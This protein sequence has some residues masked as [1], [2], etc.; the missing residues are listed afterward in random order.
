MQQKKKTS[1]LIPNR[2]LTNYELEDY[3]NRLNIPHFRGV[4]MRD[5]LP[6]RVREFETGIVN[7]DSSSGPG[8]HWVCY[9]KTGELV[10]YF[11]G[12]GNLR[13]PAELVAYLGQTSVI[14]YNYERRQS[15]D[16]VICG[17]LC[18]RFLTK[19]ENV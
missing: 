16:S 6:A 9:R 19:K 7:L 1:I 18:L 15:Y 10:S 2:A 17:H 14:R 12:F 3:A 11:D 8:T 13:P 5:S 4:F